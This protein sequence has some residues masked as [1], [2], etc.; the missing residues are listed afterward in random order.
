[1]N[2]SYKKKS[3]INLKIWKPQKFTLYGP[4]NKNE[5]IKFE[6]NFISTMKQGTIIKTRANKTYHMIIFWVI[7]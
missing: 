3:Q 7:L 4:L 6:T 1:M 5:T 2:T